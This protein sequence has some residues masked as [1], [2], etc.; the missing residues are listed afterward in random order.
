MV[1]NDYETYCGGQASPNP[2]YPQEIKSAGDNGYITEKITNSN[3]TQTQTYT[4]PCQQP[5]RAIG[6]VKDTFVKVNCVWYERHN[7]AR[8]LSYN[9]EEITTA[10]MSTTGELST[11]ATVDYVLI[12][13]TDLLCTQAQITALEALS[14]ARTYKNITHIYSEDEVQATVDLTY[15]KDTQTYLDNIIT[16]IEVLESEV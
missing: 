11:G 16:R 1:D 14:K 5:M 10:Y 13:P 4:I 7:I 9:G 3:N 6:D 15:Y 12:T 2:D 8:I